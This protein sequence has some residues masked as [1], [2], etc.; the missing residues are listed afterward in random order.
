MLFR[1]TLCAF[2]KARQYEATVAFLD[3]H[4]A[5]LYAAAGEQ[6]AFDTLLQQME[7]A[8]A[9]GRMPAGAGVLELCHALHA[10]RRGDALRSAG[11][12]EN[13]LGQIVRLGGSGAQRDLFEDTLAAAYARSGDKPAAER[14]MAWRAARAS[15]VA[16]G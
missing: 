6:A 9:A 12:I 7:T 11:L 5:A 4:V 10:Y 8:L 16:A 13:D 15:S 2:V 3:V 1:S 14:L